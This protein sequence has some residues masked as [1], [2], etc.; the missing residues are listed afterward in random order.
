MYKFIFPIEFVN[1]GMKVRLADFILSATFF[2]RY[3][4]MDILSDELGGFA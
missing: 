4:M 1:I 3:T 2:I